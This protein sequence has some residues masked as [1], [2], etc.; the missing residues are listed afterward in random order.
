MEMGKALRIAILGVLALGLAGCGKVSKDNG[1]VLAT[2]G[3]EK[4]TEKTFIEAV[5]LVM[6][7]EAKAKDMLTNDTMHE[8]RNQ[9]LGTL[10]NQRAM[11][12]WAKDQGLD[13]DPKVQIEITSALANAYF[14]IMADRLV[15]K[16]EPT[17]VQLKGF[18]DEIAAQAKAG[19][20]PGA[21]P[22]FEQVKA[23]LPAAWKRKQ[24]QVA[25]ESV[26]AQLN[27]KYPVVFA[28]EYRPMQGP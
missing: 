25:R 13:K 2:V 26:L 22:P 24:V 21:I 5:N 7:D 8:Q 18:Y 12:K 28:P 27:Q 20:Q 15:V 1:K 11:L 3:G 16:A 19:N 14:Q 17:D 23:Q 10:V 9:F 6:G 4:I